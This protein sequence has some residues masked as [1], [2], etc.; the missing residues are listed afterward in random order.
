MSLRQKQSEFTQALGLLIA[1]AYYLGYEL[2]I[3]DVQSLPAH[4]RHKKGSKHH[5]R[6]AA[7]LNLFKDGI[8]LRSTE[9]HT[10]LGEYWELIGGIWG[11]HFNDGN[12][13]EW[14]DH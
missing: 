8:Y 6:L 7:D 2:T 13:Y 3:S 4:R 1:H 9:F 11:G 12:H 10:P 14:P 5:K